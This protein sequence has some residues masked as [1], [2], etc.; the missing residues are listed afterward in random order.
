MIEASHRIIRVNSQGEGM[1]PVVKT[2]N[3]LKIE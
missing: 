1:N 3:S 2:F